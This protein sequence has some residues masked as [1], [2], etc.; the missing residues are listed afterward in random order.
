MKS[1]IK[2]IYIQLTDGS[3]FCN[4]FLARDS[5]LKLAVDTKCHKLWRSL[6]DIKENL[7]INEKHFV[8]FNKKFLK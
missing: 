6:F 8:F 5:F 4:K 7:K 2:K 1:K 3:I